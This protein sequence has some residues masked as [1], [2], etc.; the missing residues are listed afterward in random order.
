MMNFMY[1]YFRFFLC[2]AYFVVYFYYSYSDV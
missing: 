1:W 2:K